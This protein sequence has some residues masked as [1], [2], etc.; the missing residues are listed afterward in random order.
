M[1]YLHNNILINNKNNMTTLK[2]KQDKQH[3][4]LTDLSKILHA[5]DM[6]LVYKV[7][8]LEYEIINSLK[9]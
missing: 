6:S 5:D 9:K 4:I 1:E 8:K 7:I 2:Q 3:E